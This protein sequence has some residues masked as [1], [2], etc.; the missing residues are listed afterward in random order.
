MPLHDALFRDD[1]LIWDPVHSGMVRFGADEGP[2]LEVAFPETPR[3]GVWSK[4]G[5]RFVAIEPWHGLADPD[6]FTGDFRD[7][8]GVFEIVPGGE[9]RMSMSI[10]LSV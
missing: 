6:G 10:T 8:P 1:A 9:K 7:K 5:A 4:P 2:R 3:L